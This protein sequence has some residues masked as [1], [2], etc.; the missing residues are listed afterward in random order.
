MLSA[1][2][3]DIHHIWGYELPIDK[4]IIIRELMTICA[5]YKLSHFHIDFASKFFFI[6]NKQ[7]IRRGFCK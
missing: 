1:E 3:V 4:Q 6:R 5:S 2:Y 7:T